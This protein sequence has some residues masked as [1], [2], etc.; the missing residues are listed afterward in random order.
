VCQ[1]WFCYLCA[2]QK[3]GMTGTGL[4]APENSGININVKRLCYNNMYN[5]SHNL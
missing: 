1:I 4:K 2:A 3:K 5:V